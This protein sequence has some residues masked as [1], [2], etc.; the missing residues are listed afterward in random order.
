M[1]GRIEIV[2]VSEELHYRGEF[3]NSDVFERIE[4]KALTRATHLVFVSDSMRQHFTEKDPKISQYQT[5]LLPIFPKISFSCSKGFQPLAGSINKTCL[6]KLPDE[7]ER[8]IMA[9]QNLAVYKCLRIQHVNGKAS[10][11]LT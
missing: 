2:G 1:L 6:G 5:V 7:D 4:K 11:E 9:A 8:N 3:K 10:L